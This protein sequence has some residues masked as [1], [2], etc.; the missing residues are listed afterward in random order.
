MAW[1][2][3]STF[4]ALPFVAN[5]SKSDATSPASAPSSAAPVTPSRVSSA[6]S[7]LLGSRNKRRRSRS[8]G[9][10]ADRLLIVPQSLRTTDPSVAHELLNGQL[11]L[12]NTTLMFGDATPFDVP[13]PTVAFERALV[14]F[15]WLR[16]VRSAEDPDA[17]ALTQAITQRFLAL[18]GSPTRTVHRAWKTRIV[19]R[20]LINWLGSSPTLLEAADAKTYDAVLAHLNAMARHI[21]RRAP[22]SQDVLERIEGATAAVYAGLCLADQGALLDDAVSLLLDELDAQIAEDGSHVSRRSF[23]LVEFALDLLPLKQCFAVRERT[24]PPQ[25]QDAIQRML[26]FIRYCRLGDGSLARFNGNGPTWPDRL[27]AVLAHDENTT[28]PR[29]EAKPSGYLKLQRRQTIVIMDGGPVPTGALS[30]TAHAGTLSFEFGVG[31][32]PVV[33]NC[34]APPETMGDLRSAARGTAAHS[35]VLINDTSSSNLIGD[36][37]ADKALVAANARIAGPPNVEGEVRVSTDGAVVGRG[38]HDGYAQRFGLVH[39]RHV[40]LSP[41]G[42]RIDGVDRISI[43][44][45][46]TPNG[47]G[48]AGAIAAAQF[49]LHPDVAIQRGPTPNEVQ[50]SLVNGEKWRFVALS[51][52]LGLEE[53]Q[54]YAD[55][56]GPFAAIRLVLRAICQE[57]VELRWRFEQVVPTQGDPLKVRRARFSVI[58]GAAGTQGTD[59]PSSIGHDRPHMSAANDGGDEQPSSTLGTAESPSDASA[60]VDETD[61]LDLGPPTVPKDRN[62]D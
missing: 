54:F 35:T 10:E 33:V 6:A 62:D 37:K 5:R 15:E 3:K 14:S 39:E 27:A 55:F 28:S 58:D 56:S 7:R 53:S 45:S 25:I 16:H 50:L 38:Q 23:V 51:G 34:G 36:A 47:R 11:G 32:A 40:R 22:S 31:V 41:H 19:A 21:M 43:A 29:L 1:L 49:H 60:K 2:N 26:G 59:T 17:D 42:D 12:A 48:R 44:R 61:I 57:G 18:H 4:N 13:A 52:A 46:L 24:P 30:A 8:Y 20:R 9:A